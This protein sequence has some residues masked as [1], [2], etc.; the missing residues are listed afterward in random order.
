VN[1][2]KIIVG[3]IGIFLLLYYHVQGVLFASDYIS[4]YEG[5]EI[6]TDN[7]IIITFQPIGSDIETFQEI[8]S[9]GVFELSQIEKG[10]LSFYVTNNTDL[11]HYPNWLRN[12]EDDTASYDMYIE[13]YI[14]Q[15]INFSL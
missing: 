2:N 1:K 14:K 3:I 4:L 13:K 12:M 11:I 6:V 5:K 10:K 15:Q 7:K 8:Y 9:D